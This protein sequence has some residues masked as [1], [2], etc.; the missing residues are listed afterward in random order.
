MKQRPMWPFH[1][2]LRSIL[3]QK[4]K[5]KWKVDDKKKGKRINVYGLWFVSLT[6]AVLKR[7]CSACWVLVAVEELRGQQQLPLSQRLCVKVHGYRRALQDSSQESVHLLQIN[8]IQVETAAEC[9]HEP[10]K[11]RLSTS[12]SDMHRT[13]L[14][15]MS[16]THWLCCE[17][18]LEQ[19]IDLEGIHANNAALDRTCE[20]QVCTHTSNQ[21]WKYCTLFWR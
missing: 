16:K 12:V 9:G 11:G 1:N 7:K 18:L 21:S 15:W 10:E 13:L 14:M 2:E 4:K 6:E 20:G 17:K 19:G 3:L 5:K 8:P